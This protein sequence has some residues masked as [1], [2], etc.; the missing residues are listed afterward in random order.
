MANDG[1]GVATALSGPAVPRSPVPDR[2][3][4][5]TDALSYLDA[6][7]VQFQ[8]K[9]D[10]YN[11]FLDIMKDFKS[12][13]IDT[14]GVI[15]RVSM[16][17]HGNPYLIQ[18][19]NTF[20][21]PGYRI[22]LSTD[23]LN[24]DTITVMTPVGTI[25]QSITAFGTPVRVP[26]EPLLAAPTIIAPFAQPPPFGPPPP[27]LPVGIGNGSRPHTPLP[28]MS[29]VGGPSPFVEPPAPYS[30]A[31]QGAQTTAAAS[32]LG[33]LNNRTVEKAPAGEFNH[34]IQ[35]LNKIKMRFADDQE[36]YKQFLE[37][38]QTYQKEQKQLHDSQ[39]YAQVQMLF[40]D[41][42]DLMNEFKDFLPEAMAPSVQPTGLVGIMPHPVSSS[43]PWTQ[44]EPSTAPPEKVSK[45]PNRRR[46][47]AA[48]K[49]TP[50]TQKGGSRAKRAKTT[51]KP[52]PASPKFSPYQV[53]QSPQPVPPPPHQPTSAPHHPHATHTH[54]LQPTAVSPN[55]SVT[56]SEELLF[57]DRTKR[58]LEN[59]GTYEE[60]LKLLNLFA[61][62]IIDTET[63]IDRAEIFLGDGDL[64][65]Q[66]KDLMNWDDKHGNVEYGPPGSIRTGPPD[67]YAARIPDDGQG[68]S[69]RRLPDSEIHLACSGRDELCWSVLND[70]WLSHPTWASEDAG[71]AAHKKNQ[72]EE[73]LARS[74]D[75]RHEYHVQ[76]DALQRTIA[77]LEPLDVRLEE[78]TAEER[79]Q[80]RLKP[81]LS[82]TGRAI[83]ER[84]IKKVYGRDAGLEI[85]KALQECPA[86]A[87]PVVLQRL[88][89]KDY[90]W[91][92]WRREFNKT[93]KDVDVKNFYKALDMQSVV[94]K[95]NDKKNITAKHF[96]QDIEAAKA[97]QTQ[98]RE[99]ET[100][101]TPIGKSLGHQLEYEFSDT[102]VLHDSLKL[103]YSFLDH[104]PSLY[105]P[106]ERRGIERFLRQFV[107][108]FFMYPVQEFN[109]ACGPLEGGHDDDMTDDT[110]L[111]TD[112]VD[113][114]L[115][116][117]R[118][119]SGRRQ[120]SGNHS[121]AVCAGDLRR[122][123]L[124]T[125][126]ERS[127]RTKTKELSSRSA[128]HT[129]STSPVPNEGSAS[130]ARTKASRLNQ[131]LAIEDTLRTSPED[132]WIMEAGAASASAGEG[133]IRRR[134]F[135]ANTTFYTLLRL[136]QLMYSRLLLC[137]DFGARTAAE[138]HASLLAN[139]VAVQLGLDEPN[140]PPA[141]LAQAME[142]LGESRTAEEPNV[143]YLYLLDACEK[144][145][146]TELDQPVFEEHMRWFF[147]TKAYH[148]FTLDRVI[149]A[150]VKQVQ[151]IMADHKCQ[152]L[153]G[154][155]QAA[156][157]EEVLTAHDTIRYRREAER[158]VGSDD[159]LYRFDWDAQSRMI[160]IQLVGG[161]D[162]SVDEDNSTIGRW[163]EY[164]ASYVLAHATEWMPAE[165]RQH[166]GL[167]LRR[168]LMDGSEKGE[169]LQREKGVR[170]VVAAGTYR[171][172]YA[173][174]SEETLWRRRG[175]AADGELRARARAQA[176]ERMRRLG[177]LLS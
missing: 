32:F 81:D 177:R 153:W 12:Q 170:I 134:P 114:H 37:I 104:S 61:K 34:A 42:P 46:K 20:L 159:N 6:V 96:V 117:N 155:L 5:V 16:L 50:A 18:G 58:A 11:H 144:V 172:M 174:G 145:F 82:G 151:T 91:R 64:M 166:G 24:L 95:T 113:D 63:L 163:Q 53:P 131:E 40:K 43:G 106:S 100:R 65:T 55:P 14:P 175:E 115:I 84:I 35:Y 122:R 29:I 38:L 23:P 146:A 1:D 90:E 49:E 60:F 121:T 72:F 158:H 33:N 92:R 3:L 127:P 124:R 25:T 8:D 9:P 27:V 141:V 79:A 74:E 59:G 129:R 10:V 36:T 89:L 168:C 47:R 169:A 78:M 69:Y 135:F 57:F 15:E 126:Q 77:V 26:R 110:V 154:L 142:A 120:P 99:A 150:I 86:V 2:P 13:M 147:R 123:L 41:A 71:F 75:E 45:A 85:L 76:I 48:D 128:A 137:K 161:G 143:L 105:G 103:I 52:E 139:P 171:L 98:A 94:F 93:W 162:A 133:P 22:E 73:T 138:K 7:K 30:P 136:L 17:F 109:A 176:E 21:P 108:L 67:V 149:T 125:A 39:V 164:V 167:F 160:R 19:F 130:T 28:H 87:V 116:A 54:A 173:A 148:V 118:D 101:P 68:P 80:F 62:D 44:G 66:F 107:P 157:S 119:R 102:G 4:N 31:T 51:Q 111:S 165:P 112:G 70:V 83:Y 88:K 132:I 97:A 152:E 140:G 56:T 156:R